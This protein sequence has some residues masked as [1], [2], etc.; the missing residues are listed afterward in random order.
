MKREH[1]GL[2]AITAVVM[3]A[4]LAFSTQLQIAAPALH[5]NINTVFAKNDV[6]EC[7]NIHANE[8]FDYSEDL[9]PVEELSER[10]G[11]VDNVHQSPASAVNLPDDV[12]SDL[13]SG[14]SDNITVV[15]PVRPDEKE[16]VSVVPITVNNI[17][18]DA[19]TSIISSKVYTFSVSERGVIVYAFN[20]TQG[21]AKGCSWNITLYEEY[22][23]DG[24]GN[25]ISYREL[26]QIEYKSV[27][28]GVQS[29]AI[30]VLPGNYRIVVDC[31]SGF[32]DE[33][34]DIAVAFTQTNDYEIECNDT[35]SRYTYLPLDKTIGGSA[36]TFSDSSKN[37]IDWYMFE[38][39]DN[40]YSVLYFDHDADD[41]STAQNIAWKIRIVDVD[42][43]EYYAE[44]S[45]MET[46]SLNSGIMGLPCGVYFISV[47]SHMFSAKPYTVTLSF[48]ADTSIESE[49]N[50]TPETANPL[51]INTEMIGSLTKRDLVADR[52]YFSFSMENDGFVSVDFTHE[53]LSQQHDGW[54]VTILSENGDVIYREVSDWSVS[55]LRTPQIGLSAGN[56]Y[57]LVGSDSLYLS[58]IVYRLILMKTE[59]ASWESEPN[60][61]PDSADVLAM[62]TTVNGTMVA[63]GVDY[64]K[65]YFK[66][67]VNEAGTLKVV[68][69]HIVTDEDKEGWIVSLLDSSGKEIKAESVN[70]NEFEKTFEMNVEAGSYYILIE[71]GLY[72]N[73]NAY[74]LNVQMQ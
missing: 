59:D 27:G 73:S 43:N 24:T 1:K 33:K 8:H 66:F 55:V 58:N 67:S 61:T 56:Y 19:L 68:F 39:T 64:D 49:F 6:E 15:E 51:K 52:D 16:G 14:H 5:S 12:I 26:N 63:I 17:I 31:I 38:I 11:N 13:N 71:S 20:H 57:V 21:T 72:F 50:D 7:I 22:S 65:D 54:N 30:G 42:G 23:P 41:E 29:G 3:A 2:F 10:Y 69:G 44:N 25:Q 40:G 53:A 34:Y 4:V 37:D 45:S 32:T 35:Q 28:T 74:L 9:I 46:M 60:N 48:T 47:A 62:G 18:R 70:W 36:S